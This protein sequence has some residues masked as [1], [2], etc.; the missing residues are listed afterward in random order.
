MG[1]FLVA[2][3]A[4]ERRIG[5]MFGDL[6]IGSPDLVFDTPEKREAVSKLLTW[7]R[8][9]V[10]KY[11][12]VPYHTYNRGLAMVARF[13]RPIGDGLANLGVAGGLVGEPGCGKS[14]ICETY[15][16][17]HPPFDGETGVEFPVVL[18]SASIGMSRRRVGERIRRATNAS[19]RILTRDDP[20]EWSVDRLLKCKTQLFVLDESQF[21]FF[22]QRTSYIAQEMYGMVKDILDTGMISVLLVGHPDIDK[23]AFDVE[24][25]RRRGYRSE[26]LKPL[27]SSPEDKTLFG[28]LLRSIDR[29]LPFRESSELHNYRNHFYLFSGG[30]IGFV[31]N[32]V[33]EAAYLALNDR[34]ACILVHHLREAVRTM[35]KPDDDTNYFGYKPAR[36][37]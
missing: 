17:M 22:E 16:S 19:H 6:M 25:F 8:Q 5:G 20:G 37:S 7:K 31:M 36:R 12:R 26:T 27:T 14:V 21:M 24:S 11:L 2:L 30:Q 1:N 28:D 3:T 33:T 23:F 9:L 4:E 29:R 34:S 32:V 35:V 15:A 10:V 13:H 18:M